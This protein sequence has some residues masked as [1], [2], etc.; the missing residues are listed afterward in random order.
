ELVACPAWSFADRT[1]F[2]SFERL[3]DALE[4]L[5]VSTPGTRY[6]GAHVG[7]VAEDLDHVERLLTL[8]PNLVVDVAGRL[9]ELGRQPRR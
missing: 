6:V 1:R 9:A 8:A 4:T 7:C 3:L 2:P 5:L